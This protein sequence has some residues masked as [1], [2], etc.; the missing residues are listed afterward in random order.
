M[1]TKPKT[2]SDRIRAMT[3]KQLVRYRLLQSQSLQAWNLLRDLL[4]LLAPL[5]GGGWR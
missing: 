1:E 4:A 2:N 5:P 3:D